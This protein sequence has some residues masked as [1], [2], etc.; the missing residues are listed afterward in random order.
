MVNLVLV[1]CFL[2][3]QKSKFFALISFYIEIVML[4]SKGVVCVAATF[5]IFCAGLAKS[6]G[7]LAHGQ[8]VLKGTIEPAACAV[9]FSGDSV[10]DFGVIDSK[11][12]QGGKGFWAKAGSPMPFKVRCDALQQMSVKFLDS[13]AASIHDEVAVKE[14][15]FGLG[16]IGD[17]KVGYFSF[18]VSDAH[19]KVKAED[20]KM[21][22]VNYGR[23]KTNEAGSW[24]LEPSSDKVFAEHYYTPI[25][26]GDASA[27]PMDFKEWY[28]AV[29]PTIYIDRKLAVKDKAEFEGMVT[30]EL[31]YL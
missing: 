24:K 6:E 20:E 25:A 26:K 4:N 13:N 5:A 28:S 18:T 12:L 7:P 2:L 16:F 29:K 19:N 11:S 9:E 27:S 22:A 31:H 1:R 30:L 21:V 14:D 8:F 3:V 17:A 15:K 10:Q 23:S